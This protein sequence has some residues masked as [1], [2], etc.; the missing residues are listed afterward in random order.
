M[1]KAVLR[2]VCTYVCA[3]PIGLLVYLHTFV[4]KF[5]EQNICRIVGR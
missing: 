3:V 5:R 1:L 4:L 2:L